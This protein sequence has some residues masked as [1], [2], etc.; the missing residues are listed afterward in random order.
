LVEQLHAF[1]RASGLHINAAKS[2]IYFGGV[3]DSL[4]HTILQASGFSEGSFPF[5]YLGVPLSPHRLLASQFYPLLHQLETAIQS[6]MGKNLSYAGRLELIGSVLFG[7]V[8]F[9]LNVFPMPESVINR[10]TCLCR[11]FLWTGTTV[12][13]MSALVAWKSVCLPKAEGGLGLYDIKARNNCFLV[14]QLWNIHL[15]AD[16]IWI[17]WVHHFYLQNM[18]IWTVP[19]Q[20]TSSPLWK[21]FIKLRDRLLDDCGGQPAVISLLQSWNTAQLFSANAYEYL[22]PKGTP[23]P[24]VHVVWES[25]CL[26]RHSFILWLTLLKRLRTKDR[27]RFIDIDVSCVFCQDHEESHAHLF[28]ACNWTSTLWMKVKSWLRLNRGMTTINSAVRG[29]HLKGKAAVTRMKRVSLSIVVYL[30]W[31][32]R[33]RRVFENSCSPVEPLFRRFQVL[34]YMILRFHQRDLPIPI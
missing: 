16:S 32:E 27:L 10:I 17:R 7:M 9:W 34:F 3:G 15:K 33:N 26:P 5:K 30:I 6:W 25:W 29:L 20:Q 4:K 24:W 28:F 11:T 13:T 12:R 21:S 14:K 22:R 31:E 1:S 18:N 8:H 23:V 19:L 2:F